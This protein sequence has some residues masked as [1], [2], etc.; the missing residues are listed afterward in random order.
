MIHKGTQLIETER[1]VLRQ[2]TLEDAQQ[3]FDNWSG[4]DE[5]TKYMNWVTQK[6][7]EE[8]KNTLG[9]WAARY[10]QNNFYNWAVE[11]KDTHRHIGFISVVSCDEVI[12]KVELGFGIGKNWWH[13]GFMTETV[14]AVIA[15]LFEKV[16]VQRIQA[17][18]DTGNPNSGKVMQKCG[19]KYEGTMRKADVT[20]NGICDVSYYAIL[21][22]D[23][24]ND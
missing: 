13:K 18:H 1:L 21:A 2:F 4:D 17:C 3:M 12:G 7:V 19:M 10:G 20:N 22:E 6:G 11:I 15:F 16:E 8:T 23:Y 5:V 9:K 24:K 14:N